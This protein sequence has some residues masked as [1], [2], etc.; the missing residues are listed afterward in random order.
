MEMLQKRS[1]FSSDKKSIYDLWICA[2]LE[3][4]VLKKDCKVVHVYLPMGDEIDISPFIDFCLTQKITIVAPKTLPKR[5]LQNLILNKLN[6][7][8]EGVFGT[9]HPANK[10]EYTG[11]YDLIIVPGLAFDSNNFRLGYGGGYYDNFIVNHP[12]ATKVGV[13]YS[14]QQ[15]EKVPIEDHDLPLDFIIK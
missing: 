6:D 14:F 1:E 11:D 9:T 13:F 15:V 12:N 8:E 4:Y 7:V 10:E 2:E 3:K 5:K